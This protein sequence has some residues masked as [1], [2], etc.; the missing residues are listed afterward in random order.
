VKRK[1]MHKRTRRGKFE[2][3]SLPSEL[4]K[5]ALIGDWGSKQKGLNEK[6]TRKYPESQHR[7]GGKIYLRPR[8]RPDRKR[9][10]SKE[11]GPMKKIERV[12]KGKSRDRNNLGSKGGGSSLHGNSVL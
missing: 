12:L 4:T 8:K 11:G 10:S 5:N 1:E 3:A 7:L 6:S 9:R 2:E